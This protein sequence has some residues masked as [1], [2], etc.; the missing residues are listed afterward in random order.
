MQYAN[1]LVRRLEADQFMV[2]PLPNGI[3][4][5]TD[6]DRTNVSIESDGALRFQ[7]RSKP[8]AD[9]IMN[10]YK[11][12]YEYM[13][14]FQNAPQPAYDWHGGPESNTRTLVLFNNC[15]LAACK[16]SDDTMQ[17]IT[18]TLDRNG[19]RGNG[20][21]F[22]D[23][24]DAKQDFVIRANLVNQNMLFSERELAVVRSF[25]SE[26]IAADNNPVTYSQEE[27]AKEVLR[28]IDNVIAPEIQK[29]AEEEEELG[30]DPG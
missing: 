24:S 25:I 23:Y 5:V 26:Y 13:T 10:L 12:V 16:Y 30:Y 1:E 9:Y 7:P 29:D 20:H 3:A 15:E 27:T 8:L 4:S 19:D 18:W 17:F 11:Q 21:Y 2:E 14:A 6:E 22:Y 28:K